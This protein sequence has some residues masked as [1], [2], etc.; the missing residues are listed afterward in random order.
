MIHDILNVYMAKNDSSVKIL[1]DKVKDGTF[2]EIIE[3]WKW[4]FSYS[5][6][7]KKEIC[8]YI[9]LGVVSATAA[10][11][12]SVAGKYVIDIVSGYQFEKLGLMA[13]LMI[14]SAVF[15]LLFKN[16]VNRISTVMQLKINQE[17]QAEI[18]DRII[19]IDWLA[20]SR[21]EN[22]DILN[23]F[24]GDI[25]TVSEQAISFIPSIIIAV[26]NL[27]A[28]FFV[29]WHYDHIMAL[30][31]FV[32]APLMLV[33]SRYFIR[34]Q[35]EYSKK[36]REASSKMM[37]FE[38]E[39][40]YN[41]DTLKSFGVTALFGKRLRE[42]QENYREIALARNAFRIKTNIFMSVIGMIVQYAAFG[43]CLYLLWTGKII[44]GTMVLFLEQRTNMSTA[45][46]NVIS[47]IPSVLNGSVSAHRIRELVQLPEEIHIE[48]SS[49][50]DKSI[51]S[52]ISVQ[53]SAI[54]FGYEEESEVFS[55]VSFYAKPGEIIAFVGESGGGKTTVIRLI[56]G[57]IHPLNGKITLC[58]K[59][60]IETPC[61]ADTRHYISYVPQGNTIMSGTIAENL[62]LGKDD[63]S[64]EDMIS[65]LKT[66]CAWEFVFKLKDSLNHNVGERGKGLSEG[67]AQRIA[68]ARALLRDA[69]ILLLD[70]ATS[71]LDVSTERKLLRNIMI[72]M[73]NKTCIVTTHR[74]SVIDLCERVYQ[75]GDGKVVLLD[76]EEAA[77]RAVDF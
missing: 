36:V 43:Y 8:I 33:M 20:I 12:A 5:S 68:V 58:G 2:S 13:V 50:L 37:S 38:A 69:P 35:H 77:R 76:E 46:N 42:N 16:L 24:N 9:F 44:L 73:P 26:Y 61:N 72:K 29:I 19:D 57:L 31:T 3:D 49:I 47:L 75:V 10:L 28:T 67:Q 53:A 18:Y 25:S 30:L 60:G 7:Y 21:Y 39:S 45:F 74:P 32:T 71:A 40:F 6:R 11:A 70:E 34:K 1:S 54:S 59:D 23:R 41:M 66:A 27:F 55:G 17:I 65:A 48:Q 51:T 22:G 56:L 52:G 14:G 63:A 62:R 64:E 15:S 4:I